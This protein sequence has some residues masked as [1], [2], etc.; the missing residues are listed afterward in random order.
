MDY[1]RVKTNTHIS[2]FSKIYWVLAGTATVLWHISQQ[3]SKHMYTKIPKLMLWEY[4]LM[5]IVERLA[6]ALALSQTGCLHT[7]M[8]LGQF[9]LCR[10]TTRTVDRNWMGY[11]R[12]TCWTDGIDVGKGFM[13][14][15]FSSHWG[16]VRVKAY[17]NF[18]LALYACM[19]AWWKM[20][21]IGD[22]FQSA[23]LF[24]YFGKARG[25]ENLPWTLARVLPSSMI[26][27][28]NTDSNLQTSS[29]TCNTL[30]STHI[31]IKKLTIIR[32]YRHLWALVSFCIH[33]CLCR[34]SAK[35]EVVSA[36][37]YSDLND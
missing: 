30:Q 8:V 20:C 10:L 37:S 19:Q 18:I 24:C 26:S 25:D 27:S 28:A 5:L 34:W 12:C 4:M 14:R 6:V 16:C 35:W 33:L 9:L 15:D 21:D 7:L 23:W 1:Q 31:R 29:Y 36:Y 2:S 11:T 22:I 32:A 17:C 13:T 3:K